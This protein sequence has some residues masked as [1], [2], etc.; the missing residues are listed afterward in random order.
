MPEPTGT[1]LVVADNEAE[2]YYVGRVLRQAGFAVVDAG[3]GGEALRLA[4]DQPALVTLDVRLPDLSGFE[5]CRR[6]KGDPSTR[7]IPVLHI[8]A[9]YTSPDAKAEGLDGG[10][11]G[12]LT[13]PVDATELVAT[14]R[15]LLRAREVE[16]LV[17]AA[18][19]DWTTTFDLISDAVCLTGDGGRIVRCNAA[20]ARLMGRPFIELIGTRLGALVPELDHGEAPPPVAPHVLRIGERHFRVSVDPGANNDALPAAHAWLFGDVTERER[21]QEALRRSEEQA[22]ARLTEIEAVYSAAPVGLCVLDTELRY[23]RINRRLAEANGLPVEAHLGRTV[24]EVLPGLADFLEPRLREVLR[25][26][27]PVLDLEVRGERGAEPG[28][29]RVW[30]ETWYPL[31]APDGRIIGINIAAEEVTER[32]RLHEQLQEVQRLEAVGRLAGGVAHEA[33]NQMTVVLGCASFILRH[34]DTPGPVRSDVEQIRRA[35]ERTARITAQ[36]LAFGR[37][38]HLRPEVVDPDTIIARLEP[39]LARTLGDRSTLRLEHSPEGHLV[40]A[41]VGQLEQVLLNL[42]LN[43]RDAMPSGGTLTIRSEGL[44]LDTQ[45]APPVADEEFRPG[46]YVWLSVSDTGLGMDQ[47]TLR[48]AFEPFFT[49]KGPGEGTGLGLSMVYGVV[50]QSGGY[51]RARSAPGQ[52][53]RIDLYLPSATVEEAA[54]A[55]AAP[56][57]PSGGG[58]HVLLVEDDPPV[59]TVLLRELHAHGYSVTEAGNGQAALE[60]FQSGGQRF[61]VVITD[62]A[63]PSMDGRS[64]AQQLAELDPSLPILFISGDTDEAG[65]RHMEQAG[66]AFLQKPFAAEELVGHLQE[67]LRRAP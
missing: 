47:A 27:A 37:R 20:F 60:I 7:D 56:V 28:G 11:D 5:V 41:D 34:P 54:P 21:Q 38:Q 35:A 42:T 30:V 14:V 57:L 58:G 1:I 25:T 16:S 61:D 46:A 45:L 52:G 10:A 59:R 3:T 15:S 31:P 48:R 50:R 13:H 66:R 22:Q 24:R 4:A 12:Y 63:M 53:T 62:L 67:L 29:E 17:R 44:W 65:A 51:V 32:R 39:I 64:L 26:G 49:T 6:L 43:A 33:N 36:L 18:A 19:R 40:R 9:S 8:S 23:L 2:R 55:D